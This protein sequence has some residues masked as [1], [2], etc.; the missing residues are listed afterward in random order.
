MTN[1]SEILKQKRIEKLSAQIKAL[2]GSLKHAKDN[3]DKLTAKRLE[4][5]LK[6]LKQQ[7]KDANGS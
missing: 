1:D 2:S 5:T 4:K 6:D 7:L 3:N